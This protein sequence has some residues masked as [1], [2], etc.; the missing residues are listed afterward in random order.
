MPVVTSI[1]C[2]AP[3]RKS[4]ARASP[5]AVLGPRLSL[6]IESGLL[7]LPDDGRVAVFGARAGDDLSILPKD[8]LEV[9]QRHYPDHKAL[10]DM[11]YACAVAPAG[12]YAASIIALPRAK[13]EA[14]A[15][16]AAANAATTGPLV[17]DGQKNE[18]IDSILKE[19]KKRADIGDVLSKAHG[20]LF[21]VSGGDFGDWRP[22]AP[23]LVDGR[24]TT[25][26]GVFSADGIDPGSAALIAALPQKLSGHVVDLG[27]GWG[28]LADAALA[29][30]AT[31][32]DL[33]EADHAA[34][35][36]AKQ[37]IT[38]ERARFHWADARKFSPETSPNHVVC[39]PPFH[40]SRKADPSLGQD[41]IRAA[42]RMLPRH[43]TA[44]LVANRHLP[45]EK[46]LEE[47]FR[48]VQ[49]LEQTAQYKL[50]RAAQPRSLRKG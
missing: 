8:R 34:L 45:Y 11:G 19:L 31:S 21:V 12:P 26:P 14:R 33:V 10:T 28:L 13:A 35:E 38:D 7:T 46:T 9:I 4:E 2:N 48:D 44:W 49:T 16:I 37:N 22:A 42:S 1:R 27:A 20:K 24:F 30:G 29:R 18:G 41:F 36:A 25:A 23:P 47:T 39:N 15:T 43:G 6:A 3:W 40:T 5:D 50:Y 17:V 32:A